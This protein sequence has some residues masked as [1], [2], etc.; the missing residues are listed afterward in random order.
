MHFGASPSKA[1]IEPRLGTLQWF[2]KSGPGRCHCPT[3]EA[4]SALPGLC[5]PHAFPCSLLT[6]CSLCLSWGPG[7]S[8][9]QSEFSPWGW[10]S[11]S[12][13]FCHKVATSLSAEIQIP[14]A[15]GHL[16]I[17]LWMSSRHLSLVVS[18]GGLAIFP[19][20]PPLALSLHFSVIYA[21]NLL[22]FGVTPSSS[23]KS[24]H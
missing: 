8:R 20:N 21:Q 7:F 10:L 14:V 13:G 22:S 19:P 17:S 23:A 16:H 11:Y 2:E 15:I 9:P 6:G 1:F 24:S 12:C 4:G 18:S 3:D 5:H